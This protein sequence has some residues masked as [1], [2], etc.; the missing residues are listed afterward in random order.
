M[1]H[2][3]LTITEMNERIAFVRDNLRELIGQAAAYSGAANGDL[4]SNGIAEQEAELDA[5]VKAR[6]EL[7]RSRSDQRST[8]IG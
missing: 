7:S 8:D 4:V 5:L 2:P 6:D 1:A 3:P